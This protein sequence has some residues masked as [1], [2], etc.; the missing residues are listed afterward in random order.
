MRQLFALALFLLSSLPVHAALSGTKA[1]GPTG[2]YLSVTAALADIVAQGLSGPLVLEL[3]AAYVSNVETFPVTFSNLPTTA[4]K[5]LTIRPQAG[6]TGLVFTTNSSTG[7]TLAFSGATFVTVDG[8]PGGIGTTKQLLVTNTA[9]SG[10]AVRIRDG[11]LNNTL[12]YLTLQTQNTS[13]TSGTVVFGPNTPGTIGDS[14]NTIDHCDFADGA[15]TPANGIYASSTTQNNSNNT[16]SNCNIFNF[17]RAMQDVTGVRLEAG[18]SDWTITGNSFYQTVSRAT[19]P[20]VTRAIYINAPLGNNFVV[21]NNF[22]GGSTPNLG[23]SPWTVSTTSSAYIFVGIALNVGTTTPSSVQGN[24]IGNISWGSSSAASTLP[25]IWTGIYLQAGSANIGTVTGNSIGDTTSTTSISV[26]TGGNGGAVYGIG[27]ASSGVVAIANNIIGSISSNG[28][29]TNLSVSLVGIQV[30]A[31]ANT[32]SGNTVGSTTMGGSLNASNSSTSATG[33]QATGI[34]SSSAVGATISGNIVANLNNNYLGTAASGQIR[35]IATTAGVNTIIGNTVHDLVTTSP[36]TSTAAAQS[37]LG[38]TQS[39]TVAGQTVSQN[40]VYALSNQEPFAAVSVTGIYFAGPT[41]GTNLIARNLVHS[42]SLS[43]LSPSATLQ[44]MDIDAG[45]FTS[46]NNMVRVGLDNTGTSTAGTA[47]VYG[48]LDNG[49]ND[50][51]NFYHNSVYVGGTESSGSANTFA[52]ASV[53]ATNARTLLNNIF[54]NNRSTTNG[55]SKHYAISL[56]GAGV[57]PT[58]L[59]CDSNILLAPSTGG[60]LGLY[61]STDQA[62][63]AAWRSATG[64]DAAS[65]NVDPLFVN[66]AG[67]AT[68]GDLH[69]QLSSPAIHAGA[70]LAAVTDDFDG[71][72][73]SATTP[74]IGADEISN[75]ANLA[76]IVLSSGTLSPVFDPNTQ[77]YSA[78]VSNATANLTVTLVTASAYAA[79]TLNS[80]PVTSGVASG[81]INLSV[82]ANVFTIAVTSQDSSVTKT[83]TV[84]VTRQAG[85]TP[86]QQWA[87]TNSVST[88]PNTPGSN[89]IANLQNFAFGVNPNGMMLTPLVFNGSFISG[90]TIGT[91]GQPVPRIEG[92]DTRALFVRRKDYATVNLV[93]TVQFSSSLGGWQDSTDTPTVLADDGTYQIVSVPYPAG[94]TALGFFRVNLAMP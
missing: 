7:A 57:S 28:L 56:G 31:G 6:A 53:G 24:V 49:T 16:I 45:N 40:V 35:G 21:T 3:Q 77:S 20:G 4:T 85:G 18:N 29:G 19:A 34:F 23:G 17:Y 62:T 61:S 14:N 71:D 70:A 94:M 42:L 75:N 69:L 15:N 68:T 2:D 60:T 73:R 87:T 59:I 48:I 86:F 1:V 36:N 37:V 74:N 67:T 81:A 76:S 90:G 22:I 38:I 63:L 66:P 78:T 88:D 9:L 50:G 91:T 72:A 13:G 32:I 25:G 46:Q 10:V 12:Q 52:F 92:S 93:Y 89:G 27:S 65:L 64:V 55:A 47:V 51:R 58:G 83:Y 11:S 33:Q 79:I 80:S 8:R 44:G 5:T 26:T 82:G 54:V 43:S 39:S 41:A 84:T 30:T